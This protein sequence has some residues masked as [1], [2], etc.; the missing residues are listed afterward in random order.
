[1][2]LGSAHLAYCTNIHP[3]E[4]WTETFRALKEYTLPVRN[5]LISQKLIDP[6]AAYA[7]GLRL[8]AKAAKELSSHDHLKDFKQWLLQENCYVFTINGFPYG[9][10]HNTR[11]KEQVYRPDWTET[12]RLEYTNQLFDIIA[13]LCP[14]DCGGSVSTLPGSFKE[15]K[16]TETLI[17]QHLYA[18]A[19]H[20][21]TLSEQTQKDLHLGLEPEPLG[22]FEN[23]EET[24]SFFKRF[25][26]WAH[27]E[28]KDI[29]I[30]SKHIGVNF[31]TCHFALEFDSCSD[32]LEA[33]QKAGVRISKV[34]LSNALEI[35]PSN[36]VALTA[37][38]QFNEPTYLHQ[39]MLLQENGNIQRFRDIPEF[40][41]A[42]PVLSAKD[43][44]R[45]HFHIPLYQLPNSPLRSTSND[46]IA[47]LKYLKNNPMCCSHIEMETYTWEVLPHDLQLPVVNQLVEEY[48]W[49]IKHAQ[50]G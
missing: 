34:H 3:A 14:E 26:Q 49:T 47:T 10:F 43:T 25:H 48:A 17:F 5:R 41:E 42:S 27:T 24:L 19:E 2:Q 32:S 30:L 1:M 50:T 28:N 12:E 45:I 36:Q 15:F 44:L 37:I 22:H 9:E 31:D 33:F 29:T 46:T 40:S 6:E 7:I 16:A 8:S 23:T 39:C 4:S 18:C 13:Q 20:I 38:E 21:A 11:V 35:T